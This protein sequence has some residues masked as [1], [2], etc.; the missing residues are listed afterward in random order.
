MAVVFGTSAAATNSAGNVARANQR[1]LSFIAVVRVGFSVEM[2]TGTF[3]LA[4]AP[5][6]LPRMSRHSG[7]G[8]KRIQ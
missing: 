1:Y 2:S 4:N 6:I 7:N 3:L 5:S 8:E